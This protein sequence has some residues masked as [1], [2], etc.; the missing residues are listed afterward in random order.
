MSAD[1]V[2]ISACVIAK[3]EADRIG[4]CLDSVAFCDDVFEVRIRGESPVHEL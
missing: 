2:R 4:P 3:D 1:R